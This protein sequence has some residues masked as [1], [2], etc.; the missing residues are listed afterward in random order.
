MGSPSGPC[1]HAS[2]TGFTTASSTSFRQHGREL[3]ELQGRGSLRYVKN[4]GYET[5]IRLD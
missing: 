5:P 2:H 3:Y 4:R 1:K